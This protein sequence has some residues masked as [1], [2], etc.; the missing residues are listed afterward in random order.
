MLDLKRTAE[1]SDLALS[2]A[3]A[4]P[5]ITVGALLRGWWVTSRMEYLPDALVHVAL[6]LLLVLRQHPLSV[7][8][9]KLSLAGLAVWLLGHWVGSS[10]NCL[11]DYDVD[12]LDAGH[13]ARLAAAIDRAGV[14]PILVINLAEIAVA[15]L[16]SFWLAYRFGKPLL[17]FFWLAGL[18]VA[19][20]YSFEPFRLKRRNFLN[21]LALAVIVYATPLLFVYHL[22]SPAWNA[23]DVTLLVV[24][25]FQ[26]VPM[27]LAD[28]LSDQDEDRSG[29]VNNPCVVYGRVKT[30]RLAIAIY[31]VSC[32]ASLLLF[33]AQ[34]VTWNLTGSFFLLH[35]VF[36]YV[37]VI[38]EFLKLDRVSRAIEA[39]GS[40][41]AREGLT[42]ELKA[43]SRTPAWLVATSV[44]VIFLVAPLAYLSRASL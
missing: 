40:A 16:A 27:F 7:Q 23:Y 32:A 17:V 13:K 11:A 3:D 5:R 41:A 34:P 19:Y 10:L 44:G 26:M 14:R 42:R 35:S 29:G 33:A 36:I 24:Y 15:T 43:F 28:E 9:T 6:P 1:T 39:A 22:L 18:A 38:R 21:P 2:A 20:L 8:L 4:R 37:W 30:C 31:A 25:C 12:R